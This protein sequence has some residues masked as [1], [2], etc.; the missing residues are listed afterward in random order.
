MRRYDSRLLR[1][2][3]PDDKSF[4]GLFRWSSGKRW[5]VVCVADTKQECWTK[6]ENYRCKGRI[7][8]E[9][10]VIRAGQTPPE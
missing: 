10:C 2:L 1:R 4:V 8:G 9:R 6:L 5:A 3:L 7:G